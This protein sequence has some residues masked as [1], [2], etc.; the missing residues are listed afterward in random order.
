[1][2]KS[3]KQIIQKH[4]GRLRK[5]TTL[6]SLQRLDPFKHFQE[7]PK[8]LKWL[9]ETLMRDLFIWLASTFSAVLT[10]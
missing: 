9:R 1:M 7:Q 5:L 10:P 6:P 4:V 2:K 8:L 3:R